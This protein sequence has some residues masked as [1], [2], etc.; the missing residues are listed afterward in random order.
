[1]SFAKVVIALA[2]RRSTLQSYLTKSGFA[3]AWQKS[4]PTQI[5]QLILLISN[6]K[7]RVDEFVK[8]VTSADRL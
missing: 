3:V 7:G 4:I 8:E 2:C 5:R 1:M 6:S